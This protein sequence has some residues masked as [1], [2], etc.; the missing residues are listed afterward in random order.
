VQTDLLQP[1]LT[2]LLST[3]SASVVDIIGFIDEKLLEVLSLQPQ[4]IAQN[5]H[6]HALVEIALLLYLPPFVP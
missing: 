5:N 1:V 4:K 3:Y 6:F 2:D